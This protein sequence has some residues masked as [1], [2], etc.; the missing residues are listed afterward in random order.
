MKIK[1]KMKNAAAAAAATAATGEVYSTVLYSTVSNVILNHAVDEKLFF[2][3]GR[4]PEVTLS[5]AHDYSSKCIG[6]ITVE[7]T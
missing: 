6:F 2:K 3:G 7:E 4:E 5:R 1:P